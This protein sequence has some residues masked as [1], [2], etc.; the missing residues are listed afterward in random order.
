M[1][2]TMTGLK[3]PG[4]VETEAMDEEDSW[5]GL[6]D[7]ERA[8][9][10]HRGTSP[11]TDGIDDMTA[12]GAHF[13]ELTRVERKPEELHGGTTKTG[14]CALYLA[15]ADDSF[16]PGDW[17]DFPK[18]TP[19]GLTGYSFPS[20]P[21]QSLMKAGRKPSDREGSQK[22]VMGM[23]LWEMGLTLKQSLRGSSSQ[24]TEGEKPSGKETHPSGTFPLPTRRELVAPIVS[25]DEAWTVDWL[26]AICIALNSL[27]GCSQPVSQDHGEGEGTSAASEMQARIVRG[28]AGEVTR[29]KDIREVT[30]EFDWGLFPDPYDR[31]QRG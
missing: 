27:W 15:G 9:V 7:P 25:S 18:G 19:V 22:G 8:L 20:Q 13:K 17:S 12:C 11:H 30:E 26:C 14:P 1:Q 2:G 24:P 28:L 5:T 16:P 10:E 4:E 23:Q 3:H 21:N 29:L 31:L 6:V